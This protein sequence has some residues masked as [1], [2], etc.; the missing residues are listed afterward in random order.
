MDPTM[1]DRIA[2][3]ESVRCQ[4][5]GCRLTPSASAVVT[6]CPVCKGRSFLR[7]SLFATDA[8][9][10]QPGGFHVDDSID[11]VRLAEITERLPE[12]GEY[13]A[14][15][16][17]GR[18]RVV[19]L[20]WEWTRIGRGL[21]AD[22]HLDDSTVSRRHALLGRPPE[23]PRLLDDRSLNGVF[24]NGERVEWKR[25]RHG[26]EIQVGRYRLSFISHAPETDSRGSRDLRLAGAATALGGERATGAALRIAL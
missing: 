15:I 1:P 19:R 16:D 2:G 24:V 5:C 6:E 25:L 11:A 26:D 21:N 20:S 10:D 4:R 3:E 8:S 12:P 17:D 9:R 13:L 18:E 7:A 23:G 14:F 22:V